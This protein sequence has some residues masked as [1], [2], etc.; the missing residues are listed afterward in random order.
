MV[1]LSASTTHLLPRRLRGRTT[2]FILVFTYS[3]LFHVLAHLAMDPVPSSAKVG[4]FFILS[5]LGCAAERLFRRA[6]GRRVRGLA[7]WVWTWAF[8]FAK[9]RMCA[10][11]WM[12]AGFAVAWTRMPRWAGDVVVRW[13]GWEAV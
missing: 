8:M 10:E 12:D 9:G 3:A 5:G 1:V 7:G 6:T 11:A 13:A 2:Q 4:G